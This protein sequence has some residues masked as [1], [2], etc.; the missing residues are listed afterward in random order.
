[1]KTTKIWMLAILFPALWL[2][3]ATRMMNPVNEAQVLAEYLESAD[4]GNYANTAMPAIVAADGV[5]TLMAADGV[6]IDRYPLCY[7]LCLRSYR[8]ST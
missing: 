6:Y 2:Y 3:P 8:R 7:R 1:M 5:K 4:G